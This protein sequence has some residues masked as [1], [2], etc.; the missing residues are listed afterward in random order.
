M[1]FGADSL[2]VLAVC[3]RNVTRRLSTMDPVCRDKHAEV[4]SVQA[5]V[6]TIATIVMAN[7]EY[8]KAL[9]T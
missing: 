1:Q 6:C 8:H 5:G 3:R 9:D 7:K 4:N 2:A